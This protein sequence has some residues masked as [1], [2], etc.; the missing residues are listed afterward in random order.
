M[1]T[2]KRETSP[3]LQPSSRSTSL[4]LKL[5]KRQGSRHLPFTFYVLNLH[6]PFSLVSLRP[7]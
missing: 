1:G 2:I 4:N 3:S 7:T 5:L 6:W